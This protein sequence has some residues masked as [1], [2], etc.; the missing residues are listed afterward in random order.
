[1][2]TNESEAGRGI[3][4]QYRMLAEALVLHL[5][6]QR[7]EALDLISQAAAIGGRV[8]ELYRAMGH[9]HLE[10]GHY[11]A[12]L[13]CFASLLDGEPRRN[14]VLLNQA[15]CLEHLGRPAEALRAYQ[16]VLESDPG[17]AEAHFGAACCLLHMGRHEN[18][19]A[20]FKRSLELAPDH[21]DAGLGRAVAL[22]LANRRLEAE[23]AYRQVLGA[24][25]TSRHGLS[26]LMI[27]AL[28]RFIGFRQA[29]AEQLYETA[30]LLEQRRLHQ[31][32]VQFYREALARKPD[33]AEAHWRLGRVLMTI[34]RKPEGLAH[35]R[36]ALE[37]KPELGVGSEPGG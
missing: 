26:D 20:A 30:V 12:A 32:S 16:S 8:P 23:Q 28:R 9:L 27:N 10:L 21:A 3:P 17:R 34:G 7:Q 33:F 25:A 19:A 31:E 29:T 6:G 37:M 13:E 35:S 4:R 24:D 2:S 15:L 1:M 18:A 14:P 36:T 5:Q 22:Q 11:E